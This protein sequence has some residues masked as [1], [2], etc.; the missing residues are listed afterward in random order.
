MESSSSSSSLMR[1]WSPVW[2]VHSII[3]GINGKRST[4]HEVNILFP[5]IPNDDGEKKVK[6]R[7]KIVEKINKK[8]ESIWKLFVRKVSASLFKGNERCQAWRIL[9]RH[10]TRDDFML[11]FM[12]KVLFKKM[13]VYV[14]PI[15]HVIRRPPAFQNKNV[16]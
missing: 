10:R 3:I 9:E 2:T 7:N 6:R 5:E 15:C 13:L 11:D 1:G 16:L 12:W 8:G 14:P 4:S